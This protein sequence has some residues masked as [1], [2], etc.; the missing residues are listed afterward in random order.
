M[1]SCKPTELRGAAFRHA[2]AG[3]WASSLTHFLEM[4]PTILQMHNRVAHT[5]LAPRAD[6]DSLLQRSRFLIIDQNGKLETERLEQK[7]QDANP[8]FLI[9]RGLRILAE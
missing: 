4:S 6:A 3:K 1:V 9:G 5:A 2:R 8:S 7:R